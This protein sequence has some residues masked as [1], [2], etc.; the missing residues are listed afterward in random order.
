MECRGDST[1]TTECVYMEVGK[2]YL[3]VGHYGTK[4]EWLLKD[5]KGTGGTVVSPWIEKYENKM[6]KWLEN[7]RP[8][9]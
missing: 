9:H 6:D 2:K 5:Q 7:V 3:V 8:C 4:G 1:E